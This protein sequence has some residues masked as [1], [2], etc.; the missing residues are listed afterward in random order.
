MGIPTYVRYDNPDAAYLAESANSTTHEKRLT[1]VLES[2]MG[3][4]KNE[5]LGAWYIP[6]NIDTSDGLAGG[7]ASVN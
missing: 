2:N 1:G 4:G 5:W 7:L 3:I 6:G